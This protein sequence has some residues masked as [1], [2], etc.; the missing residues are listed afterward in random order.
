MHIRLVASTDLVNI[1][2]GAKG[3]GSQEGE[4]VEK[5]VRD[6]AQFIRDKF[7]INDKAHIEFDFKKKKITFR[8]LDG[9][10]SNAALTDALI[11]KIFSLGDLTQ[12]NLR[13]D[14]VQKSQLQGGILSSLKKFTTSIQRFLSYQL[15]INRSLKREINNQLKDVN[16]EDL[17]KQFVSF[18][19]SGTVWTADF[20][21]KHTLL[22]KLYSEE[23]L[24]FLYEKHLE[25]KTNEQLR[26]AKLPPLSQSEI[27]KFK[28]DQTLNYLGYPNYPTALLEKELYRLQSGEIPLIKLRNIKT[29]PANRK[30]LAKTWERILAE[31]Y[32]HGRLNKVG[33]DVS[34]KERL[35]RAENAAKFLEA[36]QNI[37]PDLLPL[38]QETKDKLLQNVSL[39]KLQTLIIEDK[40]F[41]D[42]SVSLND[43]KLIKKQKIYLDKIKPQIDKVLNEA[44]QDS[45]KDAAQIAFLLSETGHHLPRFLARLKL[46]S[47]EAKLFENDELTELY[48]NKIEKI[49][50][51]EYYL[52][53]LQ[54]EKLRHHRNQLLNVDKA[55]NSLKSVLL[56]YMNELSDIFDDHTKSKKESIQSIKNLRNAYIKQISDSTSSLDYF[57]R[58]FDGLE[59]SKTS[60]PLAE[61]AFYRFTEN[62]LNEDRLYTI[63]NSNDT[64]VIKREIELILHAEEKLYNSPTFSEPAVIRISTLLTQFQ[65][66]VTNEEAKEY[67]ILSSSDLA[68]PQDCQLYLGKDVTKAV[69]E[70]GFQHPSKIPKTVIA[71]LITLTH[72]LSFAKF[73][74][75]PDIPEEHKKEIV[76]VLN[77]L[78]NTP[79]ITAILGKFVEPTGD[80][81]LEE[82]I[83]TILRTYIFPPK[84]EYYNKI[85]AGVTQ[86]TINLVMAYTD[87]L[88]KYKSLSTP[89]NKAEKLLSTYS[90]DP[91]KITKNDQLTYR[92]LSKLSKLS[93]LSRPTYSGEI[94]LVRRLQNLGIHTQPSLKDCLENIERAV[95]IAEKLDN[96][97]IPAYA[98]QCKDG[99]IFAYVSKKKEAWIGRPLDLQSEE[100]WTAFIT[101]Y[102]LTH[103]MKTYHDGNKIV[104]SH[105]YGEYQT[106]DLGLYHM[107]ISDMWRLNVRPL[108]SPLM[109]EELE[110]SLGS[111][112]ADS[113]QNLYQQVENQVHQNIEKKFKTLANDNLRRVTAGLADFRFIINLFGGVRG[114]KILGHEDIYEQ[115]FSAI[116]KQFLKGGAKNDTQ[117]CSEF[118][119]KSTLAALMEVN[120]RLAKTLLEQYTELS[121]ANIRAQLEENGIT[122][123]DNTEDYLKGVRYF[124]PSRKI[125]TDTE[126]KL[127]RTLTSLGYSKNE[128][129]LIFRMNNQEILD[130]PYDRKERM[131]GI[132]PGRMISLL[133]KRKCVTKIDAPPEF[134]ALIKL[135]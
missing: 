37:P 46:S 81:F 131:M 70:E 27:K 119:S 39:P 101:D 99:D 1:R 54:I 56:K 132:H 84:K 85:P 11:N 25:A 115:D 58:V 78:S 33:A 40:T 116:H 89:L 57:P 104:I 93:R 41:Y 94:T 97:L 29:T 36:V 17:R 66:S 79:R 109:A 69:L 118:V 10:D 108:I 96:I 61:E 103:G 128:I 34:H 92:E 23:E 44:L 32:S 133:E 26:L 2:W 6:L 63:N 106:D 86:E 120:K 80:D 43:P 30:I 62:L 19:E 71:D 90:D 111:E 8:G 52:T 82:L 59:I 77:K 15:L 130:L 48:Y 55:R 100:K 75:T 123:D 47:E 88:K 13:I 3:F 4:Q 31:T 5:K 134:K 65:N 7:E 68:I 64:S 42:S 24:M 121:F 51:S 122:L 35:I 76:D 129:E 49:A 125:T 16:P 14:I 114:N 98:K 127:K 50:I 87:M 95:Q 83:P 28:I 21:E 117:I 124:G 20:K 110:K 107:A 126:R 91:K 67:F 135:N 18:L 38:I 9:S 60:A 102:G 45:E 22:K 112:Y 12:D 72:E 53:S 105:I 74:D 73:K 113:I